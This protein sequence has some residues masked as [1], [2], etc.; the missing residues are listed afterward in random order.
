[1]Q[2]NR[3][4]PCGQSWSAQLSSGSQV[5]TPDLVL[6]MPEPYLHTGDMTDQYQVFILPTDLKPT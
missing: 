3:R 5:G 6:S 2:E 4:D 1:M